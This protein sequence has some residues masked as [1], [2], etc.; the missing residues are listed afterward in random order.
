[1]WSGRF[2]EPLDPEFDHWQRS[3]KFD[4]RLLGEELDASAAWGRA[5]FKAG[6][7]TESEIKQIVSG[8][9]QIGQQC[10]DNPQVMDQADAEDVHHF[11]EMRLAAVIGDAAFKLH[12]GRSR[13]EQI[14]TDLRLYTRGRIDHLREGLVEL[15]DALIARAEELGTTAMP[16]YTHLQKAEPVLAAHWL[17][18]Y[19]QMF[20]RDAERLGD[21]RKRVNVLPLGSGAVAGSG[22]KLDR[23]GMARD[24]G[25]DAITANSMDATSDRD[26][27]LEFVQCCEQVSL[28]LSRL[29]EEITIFSTNEFGFVSLPDSLST[30]SSAM[31]QKKNP[32]ATELLRAKAAKLVGLSVQ[33][34]TTIKALPLAY[35]KDMQE[36]QLPLFEAAETT[37]GSLSIATKLMAAIGFNTERMQKAASV[38]FM[39][40]MEAANYLVRKGVP[41]RRAHEAIGNA[42]RTAIEKGCEL[43]GLT[44]EELKQIRP[45]FEEDFYESLKLLTV[46]ANHNVAGGTAPNQV[47][48]A[49]QGAKEK[50]NAIREVSY[51]N[52]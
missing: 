5:L 32:D 1:M 2:R 16:A 45:E 34:A 21:C 17:L 51:A 24:L 52:A 25:F 46:L 42:V 20:L 48:L 37:Q 11:V 13:N 39:N 4:R 14:A 22:I 38:G 18:A 30:G 28:H 43:D 6:V 49:L 33:V 7:L 15:A 23:E 29:A 31:P 27:E 41:F 26:F 36:L 44:L 8:L 10:A 9:K 35:N 50:L 19:V 3:F 47:K 40:A 12:T